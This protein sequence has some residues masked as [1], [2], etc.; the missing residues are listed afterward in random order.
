MPNPN[1]NAVYFDSLGIYVHAG[2]GT[3]AYGVSSKASRDIIGKDMANELP[4]DP[5]T[6][7]FYGYGKLINNSAFSLA[8]VVKT[9]DEFRAYVRGSYDGKRLPSLVRSYNGGSFVS[10][11]GTDDLPYNP[12]EKRLTAKVTHSDS[13]A[14]VTIKRNGLTLAGNP[15]ETEIEAHDTVT[16]ENGGATMIITDGTEVSFGTGAG[17]RTS[18]ALNTLEYADLSQEDSVATRVKVALLEGESWFKAPRLDP[19]STLEVSTETAVAAVR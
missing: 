9:N 18:L 8:T 3:S 16:V 14:I 1:T 6:K 5:D 10:H 17:N 4:T 19:E 11:D 2:S 7:Q 12:Y 13:G 15:L